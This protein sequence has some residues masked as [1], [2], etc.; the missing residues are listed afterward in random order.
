MNRI[1]RK[2]R[3]IKRK[4]VKYTK[5]KCKSY[6]K[7]KIK[8]NIGEYKSGRYKSIA[9]AIAVSYNQV[10]KKSPRCKRYLKKKSR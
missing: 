2:R 10:S 4:S 8:I 5:S 6:L 1:S 9:Q 7:K 3:S